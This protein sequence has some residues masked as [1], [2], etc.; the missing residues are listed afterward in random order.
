[1][2]MESFNTS[3]DDTRVVEAPMSMMER[4]KQIVAEFGGLSDWEDRYKKLIELG[5]NLS[6]LPESK[7]LDDYKVKGCQSQVWMHARIEDGR[8]IFEAD[9]DAL[10]VRGLV[11]LLLRVYSN[12]T[13]VEILNTP[14]DFVKEIGLESKLSPSR[15]N[16]LFSMIKQM[17]FYAMAFSMKV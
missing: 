14:P 7:K 17:K 13:P 10:L 8:V 4:Q 11:A 1:M 15:A 5:K 12:A 6:D 3:A 9:S 2:E 16:G